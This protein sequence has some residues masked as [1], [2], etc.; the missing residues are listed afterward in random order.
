MKRVIAIAKAILKNWIRSRSGVFF[1]I[2]FPILLMLIFSTVFSGGGSEQSTLYLENRDMK[3]SNKATDLSTTFIKVLNETG[4]LHLRPVPAGVDARKYVESQQGPFG[5]PFR[6]LIIHEGFEANMLN[7][8]LSSRLKVVTTTLSELVQRSEG[9]ITDQERLQIRRGIQEF[10]RLSRQFLSQN[11]TLEY[12]ADP[13][14][15]ASR[16]V[17]SVIKNV[18]DSFY[19]RVVGVRSG[20]DLQEVDVLDRRFRAAD[21]YLPG[22]IAAFVMTNGVIG[23]T[24]IT[25]E[26]RRRGVLK[27]L[28]TTPLSRP[29]WILGNVLSQSVLSFLLVAL[30]VTVAWIIFGL[31]AIP[32][33]WALL[34]IVAGSVLFAGI[35][36]LLAG[37]ISDVEAASAA[38]NAVAFP[39]MFLSGTFYPIETMPSYLQSIARVLPLTYFADGLRSSL[40]YHHLPSS[41]VNLA[42]VSVLALGFIIVGSLVTRWRE[43]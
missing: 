40:I 17:E 36:L 21:F 6:L 24:T 14:N 23:V 35:G 3:G 19:Y 15:T 11:V 16:I 32:D 31:R 5:G 10:D 39:M 18:A 20:I 33:A 12:I 37:F 25:T 13:S 34:L 30:M 22:L 26:F 29:E 2:L 43:K 9:F 42:I 8:T 41:L 1:S 28:A 38:G 7:G 27:R 4:A